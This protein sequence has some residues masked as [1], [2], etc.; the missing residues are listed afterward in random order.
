MI[1]NPDFEEDYYS[2]TA[3]GIHKTAHDSIRLMKWL[4]YYDRS[5]CENINYYDMMGS[6][7]KNLNEF[8]NGQY[9]AEVKDKR[10]I[11]HPTEKIILRKIDPPISLRTQYQVQNE[12][13]IRKNQKVIKNNNDELIVKNYPK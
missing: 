4:A 2:R 10:Y 13:Q 7:L 12:T 1:E 11:I 5:Y 3:V 8:L 6:V 9:Y